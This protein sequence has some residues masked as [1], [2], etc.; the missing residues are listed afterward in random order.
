MTTPDS[1]YAW[2][3]FHREII[4]PT[5]KSFEDLVCKFLGVYD[6]ALFF[7]SQEGGTLLHNDVERG[8]TPLSTRGVVVHYNETTG[9]VRSGRG[10]KRETLSFYDFLQTEEIVGKVKWWSARVLRPRDY[11]LRRNEFNV[12]EDFKAHPMELGELTVD[13]RLISAI[14]NYIKE[15]ICD[16][17]EVIYKYVK[18]WLAHII[19]TPWVKTGTVLCLQ[20]EPGAGKGTL[21]DW[22]IEHVFGKTYSTAV[23]GFQL[24]TQRFNSA[25]ANRLLV[26]VDEC[27]TTRNTFHGMFDL[28]KNMITAPTHWIEKKG[29]EPYETASYHNLILS[30]NNHFS[31]KIERGDRRYLP[32]RVSSAKIG[33]TEYWEYIHNHVLTAETANHWY[34][35]MMQMPK[36]EMCN[37]KKIPMTSLKKMMI[38]GSDSSMDTFIREVKDGCVSLRCLLKGDKEFV[39]DSDFYNTYKDWCV[40]EAYK[41]ITANKAKL[42]LEDSVGVKRTR[43]SREKL[44]MKHLNGDVT[45]LPSSAPKRVRGWYLRHIVKLS[46]TEE[47]A[48]ETDRRYAA[49]IDKEM[50]KERKWDKPK[51]RRVQAKE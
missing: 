19:Q 50:E 26:N 4:I 39:T 40:S 47:I 18:S 43:V 7:C 51:P 27:P 46:E 38:E 34:L 2:H 3:D 5:H 25:Y 48:A 24:I 31:V 45:D 20:S 11:G 12:W 22:L 42:L 33:D 29:K 15:I 14:N 16:N 21:I 10:K 35:H 8:W 17:D 30:T 1:E 9:T 28:L 49:M 6:K 32:I 13:P 41:P 37:L 44:K 36:E 23:S